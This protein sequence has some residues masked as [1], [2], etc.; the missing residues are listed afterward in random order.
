M[1]EP[2]NSYYDPPEEPKWCNTCDE[3]ADECECYEDARTER[4]IDNYE[5]KMEA[6]AEEGNNAEVEW[7]S[8][9]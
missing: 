1:I 4:E 2:P 7:E 8:R 5:A 3:Y 9:Y 6:D